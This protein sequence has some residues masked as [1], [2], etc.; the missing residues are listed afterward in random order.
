MIKK[1]YLIAEIGIKHNGDIDITKK[2]IDSAKLANFDVY[3]DIIV[4]N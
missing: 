4:I 3:I 2:L 1:P